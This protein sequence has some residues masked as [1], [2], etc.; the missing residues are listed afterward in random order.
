MS[1]Y[2]MLA[3]LPL[4]L[5]LGCASTKP[6]VVAAPCF[7]VPPPPP[8][9]ELQLP[10]A[11]KALSD[12]L[13]AQ[14]STTSLSVHQSEQSVTPSASS[15]PPGWIESKGAQGVTCIDPQSWSQDNLKA[16]DGAACPT[17]IFI[18]NPATHL[19]EQCL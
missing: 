14:P 11:L 18:V 6:I 15:C 3:M 2:K 7:K 17:A 8:R 12:A 5:M 4:A 9:Q 10:A 19:L 16:H 13:S 1:P